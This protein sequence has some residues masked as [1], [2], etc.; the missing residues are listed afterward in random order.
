MTQHT[1]ETPATPQLLSGNEAVALAALH[2]QVAL[3]VGYPGTPSTEILEHFG[4][5]GCMARWSPNE[6]VALEVVSGVAYGKARALVTMKHV[7]LNVFA[8]PLFT[9]AYTGVDGALILAVA[10]DPGMA[11]SQNEQDT[12]YYARAAGVPMLEPASSQEA[13]DAFFEAVAISETFQRPV[14]LRLST[15]VCHSRTTVVPREPVT[16]PAP[17]FQ[18]DI[19]KR[20]MIPAYARPAHRRMRQA[21]QAV[22]EHFEQSDLNREFPGEDRRLGI[23]TSGVA[24]VH[25]AEAA[26]DL[27][28]LQLTT[29]WPL[30][31]ERIR[32]FAQSVERC[33]V[34][35]EGDPI[36]LNDLNAAGIPATGKPEMYR[37]GALTVERVTRILNGDTRPETEPPKGRPP[38]LCAG[39][40]HRI[41]FAALRE[42]D[43]IV[44]G[45]IGCYTLGVLSPFEAMDTCVCMGASIGVGLG[46]RHVLPED[47]ATRV[48]SVLGDSTFMHSGITGILE[49]VY[50]RPPTGHVVLVLDNG[51]TAMT[52]MQEHP[53]SGRLLDRG[54]AHRVDIAELGRAMGLDEVIEVDANDVKHNFAELLRDVLGR[55]TLALIVVKKPC[56]LLQRQLRR[57]AKATAASPQG[58]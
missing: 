26:P 46:L 22:G 18:R 13:Y 5:L 10:D 45:D 24:T 42:L 14:I 11:S 17:A 29:T 58:K 32:R 36:L 38:E 55:R 57:D 20:V 50:N 16:A 49:M 23:I 28:M 40:P 33:I 4:S 53:G 1:T 56:L 3:G 19:P 44:A 35:E 31:L 2:T 25:A 43:C 48:V 6:M 15:R 37:F 21:L 8:D 27:P 34:I 54:P 51:I 9:V 30:P 39:C 47:E 12:R 41:S 7:G 52:G